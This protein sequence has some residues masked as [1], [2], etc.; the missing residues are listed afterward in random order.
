MEYY[1]LIKNIHI[2]TVVISGTLFAWRAGFRTRALSNG[3][4]P[5]LRRWLRI[6]PHINDTVLLSCAIA[7]VTM[8]GMSAAAPWLLAKFVA[9]F[10]YIALGMVTMRATTGRR[11]VSF[12]VLALAT[13]LYIVTVAITKSAA[14]GIA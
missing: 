6:A 7:L 14:I 2:L 11:C 8:S 1:A 10:C 9:L 12:A 3:T 5:T 4:D 13:L